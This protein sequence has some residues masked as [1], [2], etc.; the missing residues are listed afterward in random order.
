MTYATGTSFPEV[1]RH[2]KLYTV[3][4]PRKRTDRD[5]WWVSFTDPLTKK[6]RQAKFDRERDARATPTLSRY[7]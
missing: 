1:A 5:G 3:G 6:R 4:R 2:A 7:G